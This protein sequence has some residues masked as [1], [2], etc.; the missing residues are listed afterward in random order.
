MQSQRCKG[1]QDLLPQDMLRFRHIEDV[2]RA[3]CRGWGYQEVRTPTLEYLH[4][5]TATGTLT[6]ST[7]GKVYS[8]LDWDGWSG[9]RVVLRPDGTI[10]VARL[11]I[12]GLSER[13]T[14]KLFYVTNIF[15]FEETGSKNR[16][17]WQCGAEFLG[18]ARLAADVEIISLL[19]EV[20]RK[21]GLNNVR[22]QLSHA[23]LVKALIKELKLSRS[24]EAMVTSRVLDGDW[25][26]LMQAK[27][28][29][30][31][32]D[33]FLSPL[34]SLKG[35]S[36]AFLQNTKTLCQQVSLDLKFSMDDFINIATLLDSLNC[37]YE[38]DITAIRSFEYYTGVCFQLLANGKK[39]GGG[40]RYDDLIP[41]MG[42]KNIPA[43]GFAL[44]IDPI[45]ELLPLEN[46]KSK[47]SKILIKGEKSTPEIAKTCFI[48]AQSLRESKHTVEVNF[49][50]PERDDYR[51]VISISEGAPGQLTITDQQTQQRW[52]VTSATEILNI[53]GG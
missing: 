23:G 44:Y 22:L 40:G 10:P 21:L 45:M 14:A 8:F 47:K 11:Y 26:A 36:N 6:P 9:E 25:Q 16:E 31:E 17:R 15:A 50:E 38:I 18:G 39:I 46:K 4:L 32:L 3:H 53:L 19:K 24:E 27:T 2:F 1:M 7:L 42:G 49:S 34:L 13:E 37:A 33:R 29:K 20:A 52:N 51:W 41:L 28:T 30:P 48:L 12:N 5:F 35:K 43:C